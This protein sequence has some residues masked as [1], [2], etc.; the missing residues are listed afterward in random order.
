MDMNKEFVLKHKQYNNVP[1]TKQLCISFANETIT[2][3]CTF[4]SNKFASTKSANLASEISLTIVS[5]DPQI[6]NKQNE[7]ILQ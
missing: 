1:P 3:I 5:I 6:G 4:P 7:Q 2:S